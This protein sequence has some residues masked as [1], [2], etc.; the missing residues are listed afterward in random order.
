[1]HTNLEDNYSA[2]IIAN[3]EALAQVLDQVHTS[4]RNEKF[5]AN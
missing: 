2:V 1:V 4:L 3:H 5:W